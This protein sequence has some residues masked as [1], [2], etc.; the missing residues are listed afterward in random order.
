M[1][2]LI[3]IGVA[4]FCTSLITSSLVENIYVFI[5]FY[6]VICG[7][8]IGLV[9]IPIFYIIYD[10]FGIINSGKVTGVLFACFGLSSAFFNILDTEII[11]PHNQQ[12]TIPYKEGINN[13]YIFDKDVALNVP[14]A[15]F[16]SGILASILAVP[17]SFL[18]KTRGKDNRLASEVRISLYSSINST[19]FIFMFIITL[20]LSF[21]M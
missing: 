17:G 21:Q 12:A 19:Q 10:G 20:N 2:R 6:S 13:T 4:V 7:A 18:I 3:R 9:M 11:N 8:A 5:I 15:I 14:Y 16:V 1:V